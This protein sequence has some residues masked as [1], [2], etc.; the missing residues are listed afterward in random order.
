[1]NSFIAKERRQLD[2]I[3]NR[4][5]PQSQEHLSVKIREVS[6][7]LDL[8][9][10]SPLPPKQKQNIAEMIDK[11][12]DK[13][14]QFSMNTEVGGEFHA[15]ASN[16]AKAA[17]RHGEAETIAKWANIRDGANSND[18]ET[19]DADYEERV[20]RSLNGTKT[21][22]GQT[23]TR[24]ESI[25]S[26]KSVKPTFLSNSESKSIFKGTPD[27]RNSIVDGLE[28]V[29]NEAVESLGS[30]ANN[31][32]YGIAGS[33]VSNQILDM[34]DPINPK[35]RRGKIPSMARNI[36]AGGVGGG[37]SQYLA[38]GASSAMFPATVAGAVGA[39]V[40]QATYKGLKSVGASEGVSDTVSGG[41]GGASAGGVLDAVATGA[42]EG[43][44]IGSLLAPITGGSSTLAGGAI[45]AAFGAG[46]YKLG[47]IFTGAKNLK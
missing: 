19:R 25:R 44:E 24:Q 18:L 7:L 29:K 27:V 33:L 41:V 37:A 4:L 26:L 42:T 46:A 39:G 28:N 22:E 15:L 14:E 45:G 5:S 16:V 3:R 34:V 10:K 2:R 8:L 1:M 23:Q 21:G 20:R 35:T 43:E 11:S 17:A 40:Q 32:G 9:E 31:I 13:L 47:Q 30:H 36:I 6:H 38:T 12:S